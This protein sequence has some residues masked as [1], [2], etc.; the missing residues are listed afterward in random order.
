MNLLKSPDILGH[1]VSNVLDSLAGRYSTRDGV[2]QR[3][4]QTKLDISPNDGMYEGDLYAYLNCGLSAIDNIERAIAAAGN[5]PINSILDFASGYGRVLRHL[6]ARFPG[7]ELTASELES[8]AV[9]FC[10]STFGVN[11]FV[12]AKNLKELS[13]G[14]TFDL[15]WC[16]SLITHLDQDG[17]VD[18]LDFF[19]RHTNPGGLA[20]FSSHGRFVLDQ[21]VSQWKEVI[22]TG[23]DAHPYGLY[24]EDVDKIVSPLEKSGYGYA[25]YWGQD[26]YGI[27]ICSLDWIQRTLNNLGQSRLVYFCERGWDAHH[28]VSGVLKV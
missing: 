3:L 7:V 1:E 24:R 6:V 28:D 14:R 18:L 22:A 20:V 25:N 27:S 9:A 4:K 16:G 19:Q 13:I 11:G 5:T 12:S 10:Q 2:L 8:D 23:S 15:I 17:A 26:R 21:L